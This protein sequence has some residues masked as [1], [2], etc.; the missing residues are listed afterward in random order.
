VFQV[1]ATSD[2]SAISGRF[3]VRFGRSLRSRLW[4]GSLQEEVDTEL[5]FHVEMRT[6]EYIAYAD[7]ATSVA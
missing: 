2:I 1:S 3:S 4:R 6:R 7:S 5:D